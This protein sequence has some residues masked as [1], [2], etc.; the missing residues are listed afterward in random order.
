MFCYGDYV[1]VIIEC[2]YSSLDIVTSYY[3]EKYRDLLLDAAE[4]VLGYFGFDGSVY[5]RSENR[6]IRSSKQKKWWNE[7]R[8]E[9]IKDVAFHH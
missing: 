7:L 8:E 3:K 9:R 4:T 1:K 6:G 5:R 2:Y